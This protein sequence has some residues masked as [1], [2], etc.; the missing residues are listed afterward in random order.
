[1][2]KHTGLACRQG[3]YYYRRRVPIELV[4][5][6]GKA[7]VMIALGT[8]DKREA[9]RRALVKALEVDQQFEAAWRGKHSERV[10]ELPEAEIDLIARQVYQE[11]LVRHERQLREQPLFDPETVQDALDEELDD[12]AS[13][14]RFNEW[15]T[16]TTETTKRVLAG[17]GYIMPEKGVGF[18]AVRR[19]VGRAMAAANR[20]AYK[21]AEGDYSFVFDDPLAQVV[22]VLAAAEFWKEL[23]AALAAPGA[24]PS[25]SVVPLVPPERPVP[26]ARPAR[27]RSGSGGMTLAE[28]CEKF[29][30]DPSLI[31]QLQIRQFE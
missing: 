21:R 28:L 11:E 1:M 22:A 18:A 23:T 17:H 31:H 2:S 9:T 13:G 3:R 6:L 27:R 14:V 4:E 20:T 24:S 16:E 8:A 25:S 19:R 29:A 26:P 12:W 15:S 10:T 7:E 5:A 30:T